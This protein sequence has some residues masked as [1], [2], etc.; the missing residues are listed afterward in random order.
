MKTANKRIA[1]SKRELQSAQHLLRR[2]A[3]RVA[4]LRRDGQDISDATKVLGRLKATVTLMRRDHERLC[5]ELGG[6]VRAD[7]AASA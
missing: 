7:T 5:G 4:K 1:L 3:L 2:F 6:E